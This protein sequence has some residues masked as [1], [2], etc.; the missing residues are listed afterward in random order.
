MVLCFLPGRAVIEVFMACIYLGCIPV[1]VYPPDLLKEHAHTKKF[2]YIVKSVEP[3]LIIADE[4]V[5]LYRARA[6]VV[7]QFMAALGGNHVPW[8]ICGNDHRPVDLVVKR[9]NSDENAAKSDK[10][11]KPAPA[12]QCGNQHTM[13]ATSNRLALQIWIM[14]HGKLLSSVDFGG[15]ASGLLATHHHPRQ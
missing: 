4:S 6:S 7:G 10:N 8:V 1:P 15:A 9:A 13:F 11:R 12:L 14:F 5:L 3:K 2:N